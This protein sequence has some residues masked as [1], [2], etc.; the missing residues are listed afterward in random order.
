MFVFV[1]NPPVIQHCVITQKMEDT[2]MSWIT[3]YLFKGENVTSIR[4]RIYIEHETRARIKCAR[5]LIQTSTD[6]PLHYLIG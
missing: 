5:N 3:G 1:T 2:R 6:L 4:G